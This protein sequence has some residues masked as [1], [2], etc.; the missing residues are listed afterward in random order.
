M[1]GATRFELA[2]PSPPDGLVKLETALKKDT[3]DRIIK[4]KGS[5]LGK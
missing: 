2:T 5:S 1:V 3:S 4:K